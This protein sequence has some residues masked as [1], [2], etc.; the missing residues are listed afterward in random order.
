M[1]FI[2]CSKAIQCKRRISSILIGGKQK[3][4]SDVKVE[5]ITP[6]IVRVQWS[7][8]HA[9]HVMALRLFMALEPTWKTI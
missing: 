7:A 3:K 1:M 6:K 9:S 4:A 8:D 2:S 5:F